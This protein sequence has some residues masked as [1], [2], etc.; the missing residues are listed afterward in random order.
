[1]VV[2]LLLRDFSRDELDRALE[3]GTI[4]FGQLGVFFVFLSD[5]WYCLINEVPKLFINAFRIIWP[6]VSFISG[7]DISPNALFW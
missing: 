4:I 5:L 7:N 6:N 3:P 2:V 1:M